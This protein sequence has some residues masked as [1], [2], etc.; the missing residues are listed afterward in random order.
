MKTLKLSVLLLCAVALYGCQTD[1]FIAPEVNTSLPIQLYNEI[2]QVPTTRVNDEG[3]CNG[4]AVGIYVV[5]FENGTSG[6]L[7]DEDNQADNVKYVY[8]MENVK[9]TPEYDIYYRDS[10]THVDIIG[11]YPYTNP[12]SVNAHMFEV[13]RDQ[14]SESA[15]GK[16]G[17]YEASDFLW[18]MAHDITPTSARV[19][20]KFHHRMAGVQVTLINGGGWTDD[21]WAQLKKQVLV[22]NTKRNA[23][24]DFATGVITPTGEVQATGIIPYTDG[25]NFRA[26]VVPQT[27]EAGTPL[28]SITVDGVPYNYKYSDDGSLANM[29]YTQGNLHKFAVEVKKKDSAGGVEFNVVD[30][31]ITAWE[32][33]NASH[34]DGVVE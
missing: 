34:Q 21:E 22:T 29:V 4:D 19:G 27:I 12:T 9:W 5:N 11:Y 32:M 26:V 8:D 7:K 24:I 1:D 14:A 16:L 20:L 33:D 28:L 18:A 2:V 3:F 13:Q 10:E 31:S 30:V 23:T 17:G 15:H 6:T 25:A